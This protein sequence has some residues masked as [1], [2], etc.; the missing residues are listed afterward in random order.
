L[1][2]LEGEEVKQLIKFNIIICD[3]IN[4]TD[5]QIAQILGT[6]VR[7]VRQW[8]KR[9]YETGKIHEAKTS[10][11]RHKTTRDQDLDIVYAANEN[12]FRTRLERPLELI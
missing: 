8:F 10:G 5:Q 11:R 1:R 9:F 7:T 2:I 6:D 12:P 4:Y 3:G